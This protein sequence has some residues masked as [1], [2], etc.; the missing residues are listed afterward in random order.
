[1]NELEQSYKEKSGTL[2][3]FKKLFYNDKEEFKKL[4]HKQPTGQQARLLAFFQVNDSKFYKEVE[5][6]TGGI[7]FKGYL[8]TQNPV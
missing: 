3:F 4:L 7:S 8:K 2:N 1:M 6:Y 5:E